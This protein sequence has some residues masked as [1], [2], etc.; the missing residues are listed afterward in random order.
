MGGIFSGS[1]ARQKVAAAKIAKRTTDQLVTSDYGDL[2]G[3]R[4]RVMII[5]GAR[6]L[7]DSRLEKSFMSREGD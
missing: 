3:S 4:W 1:P 2:R 7:L 5:T 6:L